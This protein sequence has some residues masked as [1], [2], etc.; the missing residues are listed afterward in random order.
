[1]NDLERKLKSIELGI[2]PKKNDATQLGFQGILAG[3]PGYNL[4]KWMADKFNHN[5][6]EYD[7]A[8]D[9]VYNQTRVGGSAYHHIVDGQHSIWGAFKAVQDTKV[10]DGWARELGQSTEHLLRDTASISGI[11]P[12]FSLTKDQFDKLG[13]M[14]SEIG[15]PKEYLADA[16]TINGPEL[17]GGSIALV[18]SIIMGVKPDPER[19]SRFSGG[20]TSKLFWFWSRRR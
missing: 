6:D 13:S 12:F 1:M 15:I 11:N 2:P 3:D 9:S 18:S 20:C 19:L 5:F 16:L 7:S 10:D 4:A 8:I 17:L 14:V